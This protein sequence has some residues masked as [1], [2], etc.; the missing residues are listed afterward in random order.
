MVSTAEK[1]HVMRQVRADKANASEPLRKR[2]KR[3]DGR[4]NRGPVV[5]PGRVWRVPVVLARRSSGAEVARARF[6]PRCGTWEPLAAIVPVRVLTWVGE[7][8]DPKQL[9]CQGQSTDAR[10][11]GGPPRSS[12]EALV[13]GAERRG[14]VVLI[15]FAGQPEYPEG[16][17]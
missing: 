9:I 2:R 1:A 8:E 17:G 12:G 6:R 15:L 11:G 7:R 10:Q 13:M 5:A 3:S 16:A 14:R 4:R